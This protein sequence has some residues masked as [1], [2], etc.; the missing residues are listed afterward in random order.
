MFP[1]AKSVGNWLRH[2]WFVAAAYVVGFLVM[3]ALVG[4]HPHEAVKVAAAAVQ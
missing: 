1:E 2:G 4:W 3:L